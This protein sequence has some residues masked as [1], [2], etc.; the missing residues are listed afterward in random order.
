MYLFDLIFDIYDRLY[1]QEYRFTEHD[2]VYI[3]I[4][5]GHLFCE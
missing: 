2:H 4:V 1:Q 5:K 3:L